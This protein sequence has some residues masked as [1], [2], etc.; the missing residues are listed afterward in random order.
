LYL[1]TK[2]VYYECLPLLGVQQHIELLWQTLP[3]AYQG[4]GLPNFALLL[5]ASKLQLIQCIWGFKDAALIALQ[6]GYKSF[7]M[8]I[9]M[10][11]NTLSL[12]YNLFS[13]LVTERTWL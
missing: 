2:P 4:I 9:K 5:L 11:V 3:K 7:I 13:I 8:D 10:N 1:A 6:M 12:N